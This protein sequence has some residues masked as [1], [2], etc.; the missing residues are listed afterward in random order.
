MSL[1]VA[2]FNVPIALETQVVVVAGF[3]FIAWSVDSLWD[4]AGE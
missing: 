2:N 1:V 3:T 4:T